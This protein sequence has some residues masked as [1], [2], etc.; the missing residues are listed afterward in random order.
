MIPYEN[1]IY[2]NGLAKRQIKWAHFI[3]VS[4]F[5][6]NRD[7]HIYITQLKRIGVVGEQIG[8]LADCGR[9]FGWR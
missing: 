9:A 8:H 4:Y 2:V 1:T 3:L 6:W 5:T 7:H